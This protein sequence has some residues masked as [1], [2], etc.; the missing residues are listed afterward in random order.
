MPTYSLYLGVE[1]PRGVFVRRR[2]AIAAIIVVALALGLFGAAAAASSAASAATT[3]T[4]VG[5]AGPQNPAFLDYLKQRAA[6]TLPGASVLLP[7][8]RPLGLAPLQSRALGYIPSP[9]EVV[10]TPAQRMGA[11]LAAYPSSYD[12]RALGRV[13]GVRNQ[14][15]YGT[16]WAFAT[17][18]SLESTQLPGA[19]WDFS[20]D[21]LVL[22][23]GFDWNPYNDGG[24]SDMSAAYLMRW[25]G[26]VNETDD[27]Y[28][29]AAHGVTDTFFD[30]VVHVQNVYTVPARIGPLD[31]DIVKQMIT[32]YGG[33]YTPMYWVDQAFK[34]S[35]DAYYYSGS[36]AANHAVTIVGWDDNYS[37][38]N[39]ASLPSGNGAF[40]VKNSWG[41]GFGAGGY[42]WV[43]YY[44][45]DFAMEQG[46]VFTAVPRSTYT[47]VYQYDDFGFVTNYGY[48]GNTG[49]MANRFTAR[50]SDPLVAVS[51]NTDGP[52][53]A[54][55]IYLGTSPTDHSTLIASGTL[56][57]AGYQ[58]VTLDTPQTLTTGETFYIIAQITT[59]GDSFPLS[60]E[61][62]SP[63]YDSAAVAHQGESWGSS[64]G[65]SWTDMISASGPNGDGSY[66][67]GLNWNLKAYT[68]YEGAADAVAPTTTAG[69]ASGGWLAAPGKIDLPATDN[70]GGSGV[71]YT[72][73]SLD[74][75]PRVRSGQA[76]VATGGVHTLR[77]RSADAAG[78]VEATKT[79]SFTVDLTPPTT[80]SQGVS[81]TWVKAPVDVVLHPTDATSGVAS[82]TYSVDGAGSVNAS[83]GDTTFTVS[84]E[85]THTVTWYSTDHAG[86]TETQHS[87]MVRID[88]TQPTAAT[89]TA[90]G[91]KYGSW[92]ASAPRL[93]FNGATD[94]A[95]GIGRY[96][97]KLDAAG[98][99]TAA[100]NVATI[101]ANGKHTLVYRAVDQAGIAG[102]QTTLSPALWIDTATPT[103]R[104][105]WPATV[106]RGRTASLRYAVY[107]K[108]PRTSAYATIVLTNSRGGVVFRRSVKNVALATWR[109]YR[110][111]CGLARGTYTFTVFAQDAAGHTSAKV[112]SHLFVR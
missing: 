72:E 60:C 80:T 45:T 83:G 101:T 69:V 79:V 93:T 88:Q 13:T 50:T 106:Y 53:T 46:A 25:S 105:P 102:P 87:G 22:N 26:P 111:T 99:T 43:S 10:S 47:D 96:E 29:G 8:L 92:F 54:Y 41:T 112:H 35:S 104:T 38:A 62:N 21:H 24:N 58:T 74:S 40:L 90:T 20:E 5:H 1:N 84:G 49:W 85:G 110:F 27:G 55:Q 103:V 94:S 67:T 9:V 56:A 28:T 91:K 3:A 34:D 95:S 68:Q 17:F 107:D 18:G 33:V 75:A 108:A 63:H 70:A 57:L 32:N 59:P 4:S 71:K 36:E 2:I 61:T 6:G 39:F 64:N 82:T 19:T 86:N 44:D 12:L 89:V 97:Y 30:P 23:D 52:D 98:W 7:G 48:G 16:C 81:S 51:L 31:N 73:W 15:P 37:S 77:Y 14:N 100:G 66:W 109:N 11:A 42:F 76:T 65:V 78:N